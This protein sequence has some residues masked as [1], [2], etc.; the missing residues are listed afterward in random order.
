MRDVRE[1]L[2]SRAGRTA[3][4]LFALVVGFATL[5]I[6]LAVLGGLGDKA[7]RI[8]QSLGINVAAVLRLPPAEGGPAPGLEERHRDVLARNFP[9]AR[10][11]TV[12]R[13]EVPAGAD[14]ILSVVATD[15]DLARVRQWRLID[16][17]FLDTEDIKGFRRVAVIH[18]SLVGRWGWKTGEL[19]RLRGVLFRVVGVVDTASAAEIS[20][21]DSAWA[22]GEIVVFIPK[23]LGPL[24]RTERAGPR[25]AVDA[26]FMSVP[27]GKDFAATT[28]A[29]RRLLAQPDL[30]AGAVSWIL[31]ETLRAGVSELQRTI[32]LTGGSVSALCLV[33]GGLTLMSLMIANVRDR[34]REIG[35]R[36]SLGA[37]P[38]DIA[39]LFFLE[40]E[41][42]AGGAAF[43]AVLAVHLVLLIGSPAVAVPFRLNAVTVF[44]PLAAAGLLAGAFSYGPARAASRIMPSEALRYE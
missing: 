38:R 23:S 7:D 3:L 24:W 1:G 15:A 11:S 32:A 10:F 30:R 44:V 13:F 8:V 41:L 27:A 17:R 2:R 4:T 29:A 35:L 21:E 19:I 22:F 12:R 39:F 20:L 33:L 36:R 14:K 43:V 34:I 42:T 28:D 26:I 18:R 40:G 6:L 37:S 25:P 5:T 31:P 16:G 9:S